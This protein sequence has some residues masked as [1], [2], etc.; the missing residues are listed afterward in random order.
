MKEKAKFCVGQ[1]IWVRDTVRSLAESEPSVLP[2]NGVWIDSSK[3]RL[4]APRSAQIRC[5]ACGMPAKK[6]SRLGNNKLM[7]PHDC[8]HGNPCAAG[9]PT[10]GLHV[11]QNVTCRK[12]LKCERGQ[13]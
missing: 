1:E 11:N 4:S 12:C 9:L 2:E 6:A 7:R 8:P 13:P 10:A 3:V 5:H